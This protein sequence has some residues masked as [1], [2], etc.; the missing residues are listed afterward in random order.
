MR[1][2]PRPPGVLSVKSRITAKH[3]NVRQSPRAKQNDDLGII[4]RGRDV[5]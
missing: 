2:R 1:A 3:T 4:F 5:R